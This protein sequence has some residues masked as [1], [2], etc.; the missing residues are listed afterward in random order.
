MVGFFLA[1]NQ[2]PFPL[3]KGTT[4]T[5]EYNSEAASRKPFSI[6]DYVDFDKNGRALCPACSPNYKNHKKTLSLVPN[7]NGAY[8]CHRSCTPEEIREALGVPKPGIMPTAIAKNQFSASV[9]NKE[10]KQKAKAK[11]VYSQQQIEKM[12][13][14]LMGSGEIPKKARDWLET[15]FK[16]LEIMGEFKLGFIRSR[17]GKKMTYAISIPIPTPDPNNDLYYIK[18]RIA[19]WDE[20]LQKSED[21]APWSQ[22]GVPPTVFFSYCP[23]NAKQTWL[24]EGEWDAI[25]LGNLVKDY[26]DDVA[27]ASFT[28]GCTTVPPKE[29]L[30]RLPGEVVIFYDRNDTL[31]KRV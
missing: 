13:A 23:P 17:V 8:K 31:T 19:P 9:P 29:E 5:T 4:M 25:A 1:K 15:R 30:A 24:C 6:Q 27:I 16:N 18:K 22:Y 26:R 20:E 14:N 12:N 21:Y 28:C 2:K 7:G 11:V 10:K 3:E